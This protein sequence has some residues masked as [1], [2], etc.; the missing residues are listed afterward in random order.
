MKEY[1]TARFRQFPS[2][3]GDI[4]LLTA[5]AVTRRL[6]YTPAQLFLLTQLHGFPHPLDVAPGRA[7]WRADEVD[8]WRLTRDAKLASVLM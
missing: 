1:L 7:A 3:S 4:D 6:S 2:P 5:S 8:D